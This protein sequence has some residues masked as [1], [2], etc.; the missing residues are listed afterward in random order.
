MNKNIL[1]RIP[2]KQA[3]FV[4]VY[5]QESENPRK[6]REY[7][8]PVTIDKLHFRVIDEYGID[9]RQGYSDYSFALEFDILYEK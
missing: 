1:A 7:F 6:S 5:D 4:L 8:G 9:I 3:K 2:L